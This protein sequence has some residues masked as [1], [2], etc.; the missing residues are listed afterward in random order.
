APPRRWRPFCRSQPATAAAAAGEAAAVA[1]VPVVVAGV[2]GGG[3]D[4]WWQWGLAVMAG[5]NWWRQ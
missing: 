3:I 5:V 1:V 4:G 2:S